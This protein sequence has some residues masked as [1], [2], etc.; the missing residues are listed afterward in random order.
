MFMYEIL[1]RS[2]KDSVNNESS[3]FELFDFG[4]AL[5]FLRSNEKVS[6]LK[7]IKH[8]KYLVLGGN[9]TVLSLV[10]DEPSRKYVYNADSEDLLAEDW[11]VY[12]SS[13]ENVSNS[14]RSFSKN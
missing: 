4:D 6:R 12:K 11:F 8:D 2:Q 9:K 5:Y 1:V 10:E 13:S 3:I 7:W 14:N